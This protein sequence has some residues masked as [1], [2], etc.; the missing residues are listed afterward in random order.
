MKIAIAQL[1][2]HVG[3][4]ELNTS[5]I[6][7]SI[8]KA[9][10]EQADLVLFAE[11]AICGYPPRD[12]LEFNDFISLCDQAINEIASHC[13]GIAAI[14]G[15][16]HVNPSAK[17]KDLF[18]AAYFL[19]DGT[20]AKVIHKTLL[21]NYDVF[22]EYRYFEPNRV[23]ECIEL[24]GSKIALTICEDLWN[25]SGKWNGIAGQ[26]RNDGKSLYI[27]NPMDHLI[28]EKPD[29]AVNIAASPFS[30]THDEA[31]TK[32]LQKNASTYN[33]PF[34][35]VNHTGAQTELIFDGC[36]TVVNPE[37]NVWKMAP[38]KE[39]LQYFELDNIK[40]GIDSQVYDKNNKYELIYNALVIGISDYFNKLG[41]KKAVLGMSGGIDSA[42]VLALAVKALGKENVL[43]V[44]LPSPYSSEGS[45]LHSL[46]MIKN[47]GTDHQIIPIEKG[48]LAYDEMLS[49]V[50]EGKAAD[51]TE[52]NIQARIRGGI[53][54]AMTNKL[55]LILLNT[56]NKSEIAVGYSTL[57]GDSIGAISVLGDVYKTEVYALATYI[58]SVQG[59]CI[60][61]SIIQKAPSAELRP[62]QK[63]ADSLPPYDI[64]DPILFQY[65]ELRQG[66]KE[67]I[68]QGY[69]PTLVYRICKL[70]NMSEYKRFQAPPILRVSDKSFGFGRRLP[71]VAK[72]LG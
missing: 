25:V 62:G 3:N 61:L 53:L 23:F 67:I 33:I 48:M 5:K 26:A 46:E 14:V 50:F 49:K 24:N 43:P 31:R 40:K 10:S 44:L 34:F 16:P 71:I 64:L 21:P 8:K 60:P 38:F 20:I 2:Y 70:V 35:Y 59:N 4:F 15:G 36:S 7:E 42:V 45:K 52:E 12:F 56:S 63:D 39:D 29:I 58:N 65:I 32:V 1:D 51:L 17:G 6:I 9:K 27:D 13:I 22:D 66:P 57:Y 72:Y 18:N 55:N 47:L 28:L 41:F 54:M 30:Y 69:D 68:A 19:K 37:G 11:L